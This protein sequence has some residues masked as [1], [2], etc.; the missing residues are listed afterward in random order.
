MSG[1]ISFV[2][3]R[4]RKEAMMELDVNKRVLVFLLVSIGLITFPHINHIPIALFTYFNVLLAWRFIGIWKPNYLPQK[5]LVFVLTVCGLALLYTQHQSILGRDAGTS[6]FVTALGLKLL[7][8][9]KERDLYLINYLAFIVATSQLLYQQS[10]LMAAYILFVCCVLFAT[11]VTINSQKPE[12]KPALKTACIII[13]QA[14]PLSIVV[15]VLFPRVEAP[16]WMMFDEQHTARSG[17]SDSLE[18]GAISKLGMSDELVFRV[19]FEG[20]VPPPN[21]R[22]WRGP[23]FSYTDG[24]RWSETRNLFFQKFMDKPSFSGTPYRYTL[25]M[26]PQDKNW[27]FALDLPTEYPRPLKNNAL[28]Q[29]INTDTPDKRAEYKITSYLQYNTGYLTKTEYKD[30]LQLP[31]IPSEKIKQLVNQLHGFDQSAEFFIRSV[32]NHFKTENFHY[33][34]M[35]PLMEEN[36]IETFLFDKRYG[37]CSH[38]ATAFVYLMRVANIPARVVGGYQGGKVNKTGNFLEIRQA[39]A[40]AWVE[41]WLKNKGWTRFD[42]TAA[43]APE[44]V[45]QDVNID[46]QIATGAINFTPILIDASNAVLWIKQARQLWGSVDYNWQRWVINYSN[47][48]SNFLSSLGISGIK[49]MAYWLFISLSLITAFLAWSILKNSRLKTDKELK[50]YQLFCKKLAKA[51]FHKNQGETA[52]SFSSYI[53]QQRPDLA[54]KVEKITAL[55]IKIRYQQSPTKEDNLL[56]K[57]LICDFK[58]KTAK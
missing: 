21:Q 9:K 55:F 54:D 53:Q 15:F 31:N 49:S 58:T 35:P 32:L 44:R 13:F 36:P 24:K 45:E 12:T 3:S 42:P 10:I 52:Q 4:C 2:L 8:I 37:F 28:Y 47:N 33:T 29:L 23:V 19:K 51:G 14:L 25:M 17:L 26:E 50:Q 39:N 27:V 40:H 30:N 1:S 43:I 34:L 56:L 41:V 5:L 46:L 38:Y 11:L 16:R 6:L 18:P 48:Q 57:T 7:E 22:Y 20:K